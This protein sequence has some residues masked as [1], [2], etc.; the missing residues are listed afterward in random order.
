MN[1]SPT[2]F[3]LDPRV[4]EDSAQEHDPRRRAVLRGAGALSLLPL[5][6]ALPLIA[7]AGGASAATAGEPAFKHPGV[8]HTEE[9][10]QRM[11]TQVKAGAQPW[12]DSWRELT[13]DAQSRPGLPISS[14]PVTRRGGEGQNFGT[15][16]HEMNHAYELALR[17]KISGELDCARDAMAVLN[18]WATTTKRIEGN[19]DR[20]LAAGI[21]GY[22]WANTAEIMRT[23]E[24]WAAAEVRQFQQWLLDV[25]VPLSR[26]FLL[27]HNGADITN[28]FA[29]WDLCALCG[30]MAIGVFCDRRDLYDAALS[31]YRTGRGNGA[32]LRYVY[33]VHPGYLGQ[34]QESG[35]DQGHSTLGVALA[36]ALCQIAWNQGD[37]L[38]GHLN[39][40]LLAGAEYVA[41]SNLADADGHRLHQL[42]FV[43]MT[44]FN[45][46][47]GHPETAT[48]LSGSPHRRHCWA[49]I[50]NHYVNVKGLSAPWTTAMVAQLQPA[51]DGLDGDMPGFSRL[52]YSRQPGTPAAAPSG[53]EARVRAGQVVLSW[54]GTSAATSYV[55]KRGRSA[56]GPFVAIG[57]AT[58]PR[59]F[60]DEPG[61]GVWFYAVTA[62][63]AR[64]E[65]RPSNIA[66]AATAGEVLLHLPL[67]G[68]A[69]DVD[70]SGK[71]AQLA[72]GASWGAGR[73]GGRALALDGGAGHLVLPS[74][75]LQGVSDFTVALWVYWDQAI[76]NTRIFDFGHDDVAYMALT[77]RHHD[78]RRM[79]F[80]I[81][82]MRWSSERIVAT[83]GA[84][85]TGRWV[86]VAVT[87]SGGVCSVYVD[88]QLDGRKEGW[89][90]A[91]CDLGATTQNWLGRSQYPDAPHSPAPRFNG[92]M[93]DLL[94]RSGA[95]DEREIA[96]LAA[97]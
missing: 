37:D 8:L 21:Y 62:V 61:R 3:P 51:P 69:R 43:P 82:T 10:F 23:Y 15:M 94:I 4:A 41:L 32:A 73:K 46:A 85:P 78:D 68:N 92:R 39:N 58:E 71:T 97:A 75:I 18:T 9:D 25:F 93:S 14:Q 13:G 77:P 57:R 33:Y 59:T 28:Y 79:R 56:S 60:T 80:M 91:P 53:L 5:L 36:G 72:E 22:Q 87:L 76:D 12:L 7:N 6:P 19:A 83:S 67:D 29:N 11:R 38:F 1:Q 84:L 88:G 17:W 2:A 31:Y 89:D 16:V 95:M 70:G 50:H 81:T 52:T 44:R 42:P 35:R 47:N 54:W 48:E 20:F 55:I 24:G 96:A 34:W 90:F 40:R 49:L 30:L 45:S 26:D 66:R 64:G 63:T 86:H 27:A 74:G 65:G